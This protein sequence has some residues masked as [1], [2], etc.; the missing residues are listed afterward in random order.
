MVR[1][2]GPLHRSRASY[3]RLIVFSIRDSIRDVPAIGEPALDVCPYYNHCNTNKRRESN[4]F[5]RL[6]N[7]IDMRTSL[8]FEFKVLI[9]II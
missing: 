8:P 9:T 7:V 5:Y 4:L 2:G 3:S 1:G 6:T